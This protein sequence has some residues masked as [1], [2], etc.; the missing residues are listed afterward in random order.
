MTLAP[1]LAHIE[2]LHNNPKYWTE[3]IAGDGYGRGGYKDFQV[4]GVK[5]AYIAGM[6]PDSVLDVGCAYGFIVQRLRDVGIQAFG[7]DISDYAMSQARPDIQRYLKKAWSHELPYANK[8][9]DVLTSFG[10]MEHL[11]P[12]LVEKTLAEYGRV[13]RRGVLSVSLSTEP[14]TKHDEHLSLHPIEWWQARVPRGFEVFGDSEQAWYCFT[15]DKVAIVSTGI[16]PVG[17]SGYGGVERL[18]ALFARGMRGHYSDVK[19]VAPRGS[20]VPPGVKLIEAGPAADD[21]NEPNLTGALA[22]FIQE[23]QVSILDFSHS[24]PSRIFDPVAGLYPMWHDP[25]IMPELRLTR[26]NLVALSPWQAE[27]AKSRLHREARVLDPIIV[28]TD[29]YSPGP[30]SGV[31][32]RLLFIGKLHPSKGALEAIALAN[33]A[34]QR[35][36]IIGPVTPGDPPAYVNQVL[37]AC[38]GD[39]IIYHGEVS[40]AVKLAL[41][42]RAKAFI[43]PVS[44]PFGQGEA[45]GHK[46]CEVMACGVPCIAYDQGAMSWVLDEGLTGTVIP[47]MPGGRGFIDAIDRVS[48]LDREKLRS[49]AFERWSIPAVMSR[50]LPVMREVARGLRW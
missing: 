11:P 35:L 1:A 30:A 6:R 27:R 36:D 31:Q 40:D 44:Y 14:Y 37:A 43:Y 25:Y 16:L 29:Y 24:K 7:V 13:A 39:R 48:R 5:A 17:P 28:D 33:A 21:Y 26:T 38:D 34:G 32:D 19:I 42:R 4:N 46:M 41:I 47:A 45:H 2:E 23:Y 22:S 8:S 49:R 15:S 50:W 3:G 10:M 12:D 18:T 9:I 20:I